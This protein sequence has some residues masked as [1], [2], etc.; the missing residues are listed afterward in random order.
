MKE[1][2]SSKRIDINRNIE[3]DLSG[4]TIHAIFIN[5]SIT[6]ALFAL[7]EGNRDALDSDDLGREATFTVKPKNQPARKYTG[8]ITRV[9][10]QDGLVH[11]ALR[12][13]KKYVEI[14]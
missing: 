4:T 11:F 8:E 5:L 6:G 13:W 3:V 7:A 12:F 9:Y 14:T 2:R 10:Y 1:R